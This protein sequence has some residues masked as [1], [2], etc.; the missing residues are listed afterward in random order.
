VKTRVALLLLV[1]LVEVLLLRL[2]FWQLAR[3]HEK[4]AQIDAL[5]V[6]LRDKR[7]MGLA[8][9]LADAEGYTWID[10][11]V[12]FLPEPLLLLDNQRKGAAVGVNVYQIGIAA[13][14]Q[15]LLIDLGW[16]PVAGERILPK[17]EA[18]SATYRLSGLLLPPPSM[19]FRMGPALTEQTDGSWLLMRLDRS[20]LAERMGRPL[21]ARV[22]RV[23]PALEIGFARD[24]NVQANTLPPE[25]HRAYALQWFGLALAWLI[26]W[27]YVARRKKHER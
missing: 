18:L 1:L 22:L 9:A 24:L 3:G 5:Q 6:T 21:A 19:G 20:A 10:G 17:P 8:Q 16:L 13:D 25:K 23:D 26:L 12:R 7:P 27:L 15:A 4:Q 11:R 2:G 14:G